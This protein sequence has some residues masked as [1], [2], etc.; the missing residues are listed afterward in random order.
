VRIFVENLSVI[1]L[2]TPSHLFIAPGAHIFWRMPQPFDKVC[3]FLRSEF[4]D[5][6]KTAGE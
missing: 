6:A 2:S 4:Q 1:A 3:D 5:Q